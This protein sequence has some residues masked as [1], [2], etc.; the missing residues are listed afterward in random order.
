MSK[1]KVFGP[2]Q[3]QK[4]PFLIFFP[5]LRDLVPVLS[6]KMKNFSYLV[7]II[8]VNLEYLKKKNSIF[9]FKALNIKIEYL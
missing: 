4:K 3:I 9:Q 1:N 2:V 6:A 7:P 5:L 8:N